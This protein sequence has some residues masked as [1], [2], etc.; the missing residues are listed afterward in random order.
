MTAFTGLCI[1]IRKLATG[2]D[3]GAVMCVLPHQASGGKKSTMFIIAH[4][5]LTIKTEK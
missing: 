2:S 1:Q 5:T 3:G 4:Q